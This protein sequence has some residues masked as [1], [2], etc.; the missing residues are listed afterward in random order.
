M[1]QLAVVRSRNLGYAGDMPWILYFTPPPPRACGRRQWPALVLLAL[2]AVVSG[3]GARAEDP[4]AAVP[5]RIWLRGGDRIR[6]VWE[7]GPGEEGMVRWHALHAEQGMEFSV[8][9]VERMEFSAT[10]HDAGPPAGDRLEL[11][12]GDV[13]PGRLVEL[14]DTRATVSVGDDQ[15]IGIDR[16]ELAGIRLAQGVRKI[17]FDGPGDGSDW[18]Q[19][20][21]TRRFE[22]RD[23]EMRADAD[24][25]ASLNLDFPARY[26]VDLVLASRSGT[27]QA[28][29][30]LQVRSPNQ[31]TDGY[32]LELTPR[33]TRITQRDRG[34]RE[35]GRIHP[36]PV[37]TSREELPVRV[38]VDREAGEITLEVDGERAETWRIRSSRAT[39]RAR[40]LVLML[41]QTHGYEVRTIRVADWDG[42]WP[43]ARPGRQDTEDEVVLLNGDVVS[44]RVDHV[45][46][47][48]VRITGAFGALE[49]P[50]DRVEAIRLAREARRA[51]A[52]RPGVVHFRGE[53]SLSGDVVGLV[54]D[55]VI[56]RGEPFGEV[57]V[58]VGW[59]RQVTFSAP[60]ATP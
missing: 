29:L 49:I 39:D 48:I 16:A 47:G 9:A 23:G 14:S 30:G 35:I 54:G 58:P 12:G 51:P 11:A 40:H 45:R 46:E 44:G 20:A 8:D 60:S 3:V 55:R 31:N 56:L 36:S 6:G 5:G 27:Y 57:G 28:Q 17:L 1:R 18:I 33:L 42:R 13:L 59:I 22:F 43:D 34:R 41:H 7:G 53:G 26:Q 37:G 10:A 25:F 2:V 21:R 38:Y 50:S 32:W 4:A 19:H 24:A 15:E 52:A